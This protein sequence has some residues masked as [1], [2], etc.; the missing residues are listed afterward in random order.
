MAESMITVDGNQHVLRKPFFVIATQNPIDFHGTYPLPEAQLD[1]FLMRL[2]MGYPLPNIEMDIL[3][4]QAAVNPL[5]LI[6]HVAEGSDIIHCQSLIRLCMCP[7][8][9]H[10]IV[11]IILR[12]VSTGLPARCPHA[13][14]ADALV[15]L[16]GYQRSRPCA[17]RCP[18]PG[19]CVLA[20]ACPLAARRN[21]C[22]VSVIEAIWP[23]L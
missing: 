9:C 15:S 3:Q 13:P 11:T 22:P 12:R 7:S 10:Y 23:R 19:P 2:N 21:G 17:A 5:N 8:W 20:T 18:R 1:R 14:V 6:S 4:T 16:G